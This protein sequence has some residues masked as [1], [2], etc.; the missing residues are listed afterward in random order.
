MA[1]WLDRAFVELGADGAGFPAIVAFGPNAAV[2]HHRPTD[3][4]LARGEVVKVDSGCRVGGYHADVT[5]TVALGDPGQR[6]RDVHDVVHRAQEAGFDA[7]VDGA[8]THAVDAAARDVVEAAGMGEHFPHGTGHGTGLAIHELPRVAKEATA[9]L[10]A[11][12]VLTV[13]PGVYLDGVG[14]VRIEDSVAVTVDGPVR[15]STM[16]RALLEL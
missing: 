6:L 10:R 3:R 15:L 7:A 13:E 9:T 12:T 8:D 4:P 2:P 11:P 14:G 1:T 5:R 16:T